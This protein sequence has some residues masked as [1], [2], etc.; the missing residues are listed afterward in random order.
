MYGIFLSALNV[1]LGFLI[2]SILVKFVVYFALFF[3][4][5]EFISI[6]SPLLPSGAALTSSL[7]GIP[8]AVWYFLDLFNVSIGI[9]ILL[10]AWVMRFIIRRIPVIG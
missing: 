1:A 4:V 8:G 5:T 10:S 6:L 3:V 7:G 2:R 9:P